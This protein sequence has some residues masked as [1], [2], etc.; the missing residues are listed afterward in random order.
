L[1]AWQPDSSL[2][3]ELLELGTDVDPDWDQFKAAEKLWGFQSTWDET[4]YTTELDRNSASYKKQ[5][6]SAE[7]VASE[8]L[9]QQ[10]Q[11]PHVAEERGQ[12]TEAMKNMDDAERYSDVLAATKSGSTQSR[13]D[14][15][16]GGGGGEA[17]KSVDKAGGAGSDDEQKKKDKEAADKAK[18]AM[19]LAMRADADDFNPFE[20]T[21]WLSSTMKSSTSPSLQPSP[22]PA[23][24]PPHAPQSPQQL[25]AHQQHAAIVYHQMQQQQQQQ[26]HA[27]NAAALAHSGY[28]AAGYGYPPAAAAAP[29]AYGYGGPQSPGYATAYA[30][31]AGYAAQYAAAAHHQQQQH[32]QQHQ[33][34]LS[35]QQARPPSH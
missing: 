17:T 23:I 14:D 1:V 5:S 35:P 29:V 18:A 31:A 6:K 26:Q 20:Q 25:A 11:N 32:Q 7:R 22:Q 8:I 28:A 21:A 19:K 24:V 13:Y 12:E 34:P 2:D 9:G 16:N 15:N 33:A 27:P 4:L 30:P 3:A 10:A